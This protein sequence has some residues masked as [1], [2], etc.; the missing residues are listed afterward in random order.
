MIGE[1][2]MLSDYGA[3]VFCTTALGELETAAHRT[4]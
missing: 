4:N 3:A 2:S 1:A